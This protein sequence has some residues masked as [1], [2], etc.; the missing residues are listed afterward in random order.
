MI[1]I[2]ICYGLPDMQ[3]LEALHL[4]RGITAIKAIM[5]SSL[6]EKFPDISLSNIGIY[7]KKVNLNHILEDG[8][9]IEIYRPLLMTPNEARLLRKKKVSV[10]GIQK[11]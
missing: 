6:L 9:R 4:P 8:D 7:S 1:K 3:F 2:E 11:S 5:S 10:Q